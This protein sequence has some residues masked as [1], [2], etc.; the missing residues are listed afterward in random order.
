[1]TDHRGTVVEKYVRNLSRD[2]RISLLQFILVRILV[3]CGLFAGPRKKLKRRM[4][5]HGMENNQR[6]QSGPAARKAALFRAINDNCRNAHGQRK[7]DESVHVRASLSGTWP[8]RECHT[9][10]CEAR[11]S[12]KCN[13]IAVTNFFRLAIPDYGGECHASCRIA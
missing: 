5:S 12:A 13:A 8:P 4:P 2:S 6:R 3:F 1:M 10:T 11:S 9:S 7:I